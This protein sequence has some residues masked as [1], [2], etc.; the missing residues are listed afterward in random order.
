MCS[1]MYKLKC[2]QLQQFIYDD[3][4]EYAQTAGCTD[5]SACNYTLDAQIDDGSCDYPADNYDCEGNCLATQVEA[6]VGDYPEEVLW[7]ITTCDEDVILDGG[8]PFEGC[9]DISGGYIVY[10]YDS[11]GDGWNGNTLL[12]GDA[13]FTLENGA[14]A[15]D[16]STCNVPG[17]TDESAENYNADANSNDGS[18]EYEVSCPLDEV[19]I[20]MF[21]SH[22]DGGGMVTLG[23]VTATNS[24]YSSLTL[25]CV[26]LSVCNV[27]DYEATDSW[28][29]E[30]SWSITN[31][32]GED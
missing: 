7:V 1:R 21:D 27:V 8:A 29:N 13:S 26:D 15:F 22:G 14:E 30:N 17:C 19:F 9:A 5:E 11:Y 32:S 23:D 24:G 18:C 28:S 4:C 12:V 16:L 20:N 25:V 10:M 3:S 6:L 31:T 2:N